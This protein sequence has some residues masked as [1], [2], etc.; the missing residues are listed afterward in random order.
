M[1]LPVNKLEKPS[2]YAT[3]FVVAAYAKTDE[4]ESE[5]LSIT[6]GKEGEFTEGGK[7]IV[8]VNDAIKENNAPT[9]F[10]VKDFRFDFNWVGT[11]VNTTSSGGSMI[12]TD[13]TS[14]EFLT[15]LKQEVLERLG[16]S[17]ENITFS[18]RLFFVVDKNDEVDI[19][20]TNHLLFS[21]SQIEHKLAGNMH[22]YDCDVIPLY[23]AKAHYTNYTRLY[24]I[25]I[26]HKEGE[27][28]EEIPEAD[29]SGSS[30]KSR[31]EE[32]EEKKD[33]RTDRIKKSKPMTKIKDAFEGLELD[34]NEST[35]M[36]KKQY[37]EWQSIIREGFTDKIKD[38][39]QRKA[40]ELPIHFLMHL[41]DQYDD[42]YIIDN[43]NLPFEQPEQRQNSPGVRVIPTRYGEK[44]QD[45]VDRIM[46]YSRK[47]GIDA[48][49]GE[50]GDGLKKD[51]KVGLTWRRLLDEVK[52]DIWVRKYTLPQNPAE[53]PNSGNNAESSV[54]PFTFFFKGSGNS[55]N[56]T[57][58]SNTEESEESS[59]E[60]NA[61]RDDLMNVNG[62]LHRSDSLVV[63]EDVIDTEPGRLSFGAER[64][65]IS[66]EREPN[67]DFFKSGYSGNRA[68]IL[69]VKTLGVEYPRELAQNVKIKYPVQ[70]TQQSA[71]EITIRGN[72]DLLSDLFRSPTQ[73]ADGNP[74]DAQHY[75][76]PEV[77]PM[78]AK[79]MI[80]HEAVEDPS[81]LNNGTPTDSA[82]YHTEWMH[83][84]KIETIVK[85]S[86][87][88][89][90]LTLL[91][92]DTVI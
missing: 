32:D 25:S 41:D 85:G 67:I 18:A 23:N 14:G 70:N 64:E 37:Q 43:R 92:T 39:K 65:A 78:Y 35:K 52:Y 22:F 17:L 82:F 45:V 59:N 46:E 40:E 38:P 87:M 27:L 69:N 7:G 90:K 56:S 83:I 4:A 76:L 73:V 50:A 63:I 20:P 6:D 55:E 3:Y 26:T 62:I 89:Q 15:F 66:A 19:L 16:T 86:S 84:Y 48:R 10:I 71:L 75:K 9:R 42:S 12:I 1:S 57:E 29:P 5:Q 2:S 88:F 30:I 58:S 81:E 61:N 21:I 68:N 53:G 51:Y 24:N 77:Y 36:H 34:L 91:R 74:G 72:P 79:V 8:I 60:S 33:K 44:I 54:K 47:V 11:H 28:H 31:K 49:G 13:T 80:Q